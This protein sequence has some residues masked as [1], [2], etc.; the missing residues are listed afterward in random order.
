MTTRTELVA[1]ETAIELAE[2][3]G[4][5]HINHIKYRGRYNKCTVSEKFE[6]DCFQRLC[7]LAY[8]KALADML[9]AD[10]K[11]RAAAK[12]AKDALVYHTAQTRPID[13][14]DKAITALKE[15]GIC[16]PICHHS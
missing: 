4:F 9:E 7:D 10:T 6:I 5:E 2:K 11:L 16:N 15:A 14:T 1:R 12:L 8:Q 13:R 3:A